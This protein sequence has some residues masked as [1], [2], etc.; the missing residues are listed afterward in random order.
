MGDGAFLALF[1]F[2][3]PSADAKGTDVIITHDGGSMH[4]AW[5]TSFHILHIQ[6]GEVPREVACVACSHA[7]LRTRFRPLD[8]HHT[9]ICTDAHHYAN[10]SAL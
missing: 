4:P 10:A 1:R 3:Y 9:S 7:A 8:I 5:Q 6:T 2:I